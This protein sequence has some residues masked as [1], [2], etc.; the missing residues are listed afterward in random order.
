MSSASH[1]RTWIAEASLTLNCCR[2][3]PKTG[4]GP[5]YSVFATIFLQ[6]I[7]C[8]ISIH[9]LQKK[10]RNISLTRVLSQVQKYKKSCWLVGKWGRWSKDRWTEF[11]NLWPRGVLKTAITPFISSLPNFFW[12]NRQHCPRRLICWFLIVHHPSSSPSQTGSLRQTT[13]HTC[14]RVSVCSTT[15][16]IE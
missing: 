3:Y 9:V 1:F 4:E 11:E 16:R 8:W 7:V 5:V 2:R 10:V 15:Q 13:G 12:A 14:N 6:L